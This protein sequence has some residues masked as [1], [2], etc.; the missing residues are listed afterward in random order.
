MFGYCNKITDD[1]LQYVAKIKQHKHLSLASCPQISD[2]VLA[3]LATSI[4][5]ESL[6]LSDCTGITDGGLGYL[7]KMQRLKEISLRGCRNISREGVQELREA[8]P[9]VRWSIY[10]REWMR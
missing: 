9:F 1:G 10:H 3:N 8:H 2:A 6:D 5:I 7:H 4:N